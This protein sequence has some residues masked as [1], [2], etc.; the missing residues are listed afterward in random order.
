[1]EDPYFFVHM[2]YLLI[3]QTVKNL[4]VKERRKIFTM[5]REKSKFDRHSFFPAHGIT[6]GE[7]C[8]FHVLQ[9]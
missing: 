1:M 5:M 4:P 8:V 6:A 7:F 3:S 9:E 2:R